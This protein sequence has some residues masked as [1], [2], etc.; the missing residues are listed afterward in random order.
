MIDGVIMKNFRTFIV[1]IILSTFLT[2][3]I[4]QSDQLYL[5]LNFK[6]AYKNKTRSFNGKPGPNYW[7]NRADYRI[8]VQLD[9]YTR[10]ISG[11]ETILYYNYSPDTLS[12]LLI[13]LFPNVY[14]I[15]N[16]REFVIDPA[17]AS[18][19]VLLKEILLD[20]KKID[21]GL[22]SAH[23]VELHND[24]RI[25]LDNMIL[26]EESIKL[27][28]T[29]Q[30]T[31]NKNSHMRTGR[32]DSTSFFI[33]YFF[34]RIAVYDDIDGWHDFK[35]GGI[36]EFY[37]DFGDFDVTVTVPKNYIVWA[38]GLLQ[39]P[40]DVLREKYLKRY[41]SA[42]SAD[43]IVHI[44]DSTE[45]A[46][47]VITTSTTENKWHFKAVNV[48][49]FAFGTSNHYLWDATSLIVD[50]ST[51]RRVLI[52][53]AYNKNSDDFYKV[54][55]I[56]RKSIDYLSNKLPAV[57]FPFPSE[58]VFNGLDEMEYPMM[59]NNLSTDDPGYLI[60]LT[61]HEISHSYLPFYLGINETKYG[62]MDEG[63]ASF[64][65]YHIS[66][67]LDSKENAR[68][69]HMST[70]Q[71]NIGRDLDLP[72]FGISK[73]LK[74]PVYHFNSYS[75]PAS[76]LFVLKNLLGKSLFIKVFQDFM[77]DWNGKHPTPY[78]LFNTINTS[79]KTNLNWL[80]RPWF[81]EYG[82]IDLA[83]RKVKFHGNAYKIDIENIGGYPVP[84]NLKLTYHDGSGK[85]ISE[86]ASVWKDGNTIYSLTLSSEKKISRMEL[87]HPVIP[88]ANPDD[89][90]Y[91]IK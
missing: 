3:S 77:A 63:W 76:F 43:D 22:N 87:V 54:A 73:Y 15:G 59:V 66:A 61:S 82:T 56:A 29:W 23:I 36:A 14:R 33:A 84:I 47:G 68:I 25:N 53:A 5:P 10:V 52:E 6:Q 58:T 42:F 49:D 41:R 71:S 24:I 39:N 8:K 64:I 90:I 79:A 44:V 30:Y 11:S 40:Q 69:F 9:P 35:Y 19:G 75:K 37:N 57:P 27:D 80:I 16:Q 18:D 72:M 20:G 38:T 2:E 89:N 1:L 34:P 91:E 86:N 55:G 21:P 74:R 60:K 67:E 7:Q 12:Y 85:S 28:I 32:V 65:D 70:Y 50:Q 62:W 81:Y 17:D 48:T 31:V 26:P 46:T 88:D 51:Q 83:I 45:Y 13:H 4:A 78:D